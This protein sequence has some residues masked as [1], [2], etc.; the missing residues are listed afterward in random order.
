MEINPQDFISL[1]FDWLDILIIVLGAWG[2]GACVLKVSKKVSIIL[3]FF[4]V[5]FLVR[6]MFPRQSLQDVIGV[7][8]VYA[9]V[10]IAIKWTFF[11]GKN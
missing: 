9:T 3:S 10:L 4:V 1:P 11:N 6:D 8:I 7:V 5:Y 2:I